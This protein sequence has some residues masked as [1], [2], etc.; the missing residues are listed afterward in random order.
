MSPNKDLT[1]QFIFSQHKNIEETNT[2]KQTEDVST[3]TLVTGIFTD[4]RINFDRNDVF[5]SNLFYMDYRLFNHRMTSFRF[6]L[7]G[8]EARAEQFVKAGF[9]YKCD[10]DKCRCNWCGLELYNWEYIDEP[11]N[12]H[13]S[14]LNENGRECPYLKM[15]LP[16]P[17]NPQSANMEMDYRFFNDR[18]LS[19]KSW[20]HSEKIKGEQL[21]RGGFIYI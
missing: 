21:A 17:M 5:Y 7:Y 18:L 14:Y 12:I 6:S 3:N 19:F 8:N 9:T 4:G 10:N 16:M 11:M 13:K 15:I 2:A 20:S 1:K